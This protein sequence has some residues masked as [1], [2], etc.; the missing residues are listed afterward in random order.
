[1][2]ADAQQLPELETLC[3][4]CKGRGGET[5]RREWHKCGVCK[6]TGYVPTEAGKRLLDLVRHNLQAMLARASDD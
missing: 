1:M 6:G 4:F 2:N 3:K 5:E